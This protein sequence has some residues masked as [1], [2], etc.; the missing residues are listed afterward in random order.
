[1]LEFKGKTVWITGAS[2]GIGAALAIEFAR[3][4]AR[5]VLSARNRERLEAVA[6]ACRQHSGQVLVLPMDVTQTD[7]FAE[8]TARVEDWGGGIDVLVNNAGI[9]QRGSALDTKSDAA[10][11]LFEADF[12]GA[13]ELTRA[14]VP[15]MKTRGKG[16]VVAVTSVIG[17]FGAPSRSFYSAAKHAL[18][19]WFDSLREELAGTGVRVTILVPGWI[20]TEISL[21]AL[22]DDGTPHGKMD[23]GQSG[24]LDASECARRMVKAIGEG[25][26]EY[27]I[28]G[29]EC[30]MAY[31][32]RLSPGLAR[33]VLRRKGIG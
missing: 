5:P 30:A 23:P 26:P 13:V 21:H 4:G 22:N 17:K 32:F 15:G 20:R 33:W 3:A 12:W 25:G 9:G 8:L 31:L 10:R 11:K 18:H 27:L 28:G 16:A 6:A 14:V 7:S 2:S 19:G 29:R 24:G 1:M